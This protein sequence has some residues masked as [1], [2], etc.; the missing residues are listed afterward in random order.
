MLLQGFQGTVKASGITVGRVKK[1]SGDV[2]IKEQE[3]GPFIGGDGT[4]EVVS[5]S[6]MIKGK[7]ECIVPSGRDPGQTVIINQALALGTLAL[8][9][10]EENG[11]TVEV[12]TAKISG[13]A[14]DNDGASSVK[15]SFDWRNSGSFDITP[16]A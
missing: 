1:W 3:E 13:F 2:S 12:P 16:T 6:K 14:F 8:E 11:Y 15:L 4:T 7:L 9:L 5:T 10:I